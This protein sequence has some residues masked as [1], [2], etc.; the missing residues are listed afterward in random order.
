[1]DKSQESDDTHNSVGIISTKNNANNSTLGGYKT[2]RSNFTID[3]NKITLSEEE[4]IDHDPY[5]PEF[6]NR[7]ITIN[8]QQIIEI[9]QLTSKSQLLSPAFHFAE[10][11]P[12]LQE[13]TDSS[14]VIEI[15]LFQAG[16]SGSFCSD[17]IVI[18][19]T[20]A[21]AKTHIDYTIKDEYRGE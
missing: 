18:T 11:T 14:T 3:G 4:K 20:I 13:K 8:E 15:L 5:E 10:K 21:A 6:R 9:D 7:V 16:C 19:V 12:L 1:M 17:V 2:H